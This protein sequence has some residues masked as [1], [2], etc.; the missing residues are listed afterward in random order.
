MALTPGVLRA[1]KRRSPPA[2]GALDA[3]TH[4]AG[5]SVTDPSRDADQPTDGTEVE[6]D[7]L[8]RSCGYNLRGLA[9][10]DRCPECGADAAITG[11]PSLLC[12][13]RHSWLRTVRLALHLERL[14]LCAYVPVT[15]VSAYSEFARLPR[16]LDHRVL[17]VVMLVGLAM[18][19]AGLFLATASEPQP[20][21]EEPRVI[22]RQF[23]RL[24]AGIAIVFFAVIAALMPFSR[25]AWVW[26]LILH[27][28][29]GL[30]ASHGAAE[31]FRLS[32]LERISRRA[33]DDRLAVLWQ[34]TRIAYLATLLLMF[35]H[36]ALNFPPVINVFGAPSLSLLLPI[37]VASGAYYAISWIAHTRLI[38]ILRGITDNR[39]ALRRGLVQAVARDSMA[40]AEEARP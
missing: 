7:R 39:G 14:A 21:G 31:V 35:V 6:S 4:R 27:L 16:G 15:G 25:S 11:D 10:T 28:G 40:G 1:T 22:S 30:V 18:H 23:A 29:F 2:R 19:Y 20:N 17:L 26:S 33:P 37:S 5:N 13:A 38:V 9:C 32:A 24:W 3:T 36:A 34:F 12:N 8:C